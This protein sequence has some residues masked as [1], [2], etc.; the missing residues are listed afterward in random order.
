[1][2]T[3]KS[4]YVWTPEVKEFLLTLLS[5]SPT[6]HRIIPAES[7]LWRAQI[8]HGFDPY[9]YE[10]EHIADTPAP[11]PKERMK[12]LHGK[13]AEGRA[14]PKGIPY[15]YLANKLETALCEVRPWLGSLV[16]IG[17]FEIIREL[18]V[19]NFFNTEIRHLLYLEEPDQ[20][21]REKSVWMD[22]DQAFSQPITLTDRIIKYVPTQIIAEMF[23][24]EGFDGISYRSAYTNDYNVMLFDIDAA[25]IINCFLYEVE[26]INFKFNEVANPYFVKKH[27]EQK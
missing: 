4:R 22:I 9:V 24:A 11:L 8:G 13:A 3:R 16:S 18:E 19:V 25:E 17:Q 2:V 10:G 12:P 15:L 14:N 5:T 1:M 6:R 21:E 23:K 26:R 7:I 20:K 27:Y